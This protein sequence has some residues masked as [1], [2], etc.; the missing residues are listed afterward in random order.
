MFPLLVPASILFAD[1]VD[2]LRRRRVPLWHAGYLLTE[3]VVAFSVAYFVL[4]SRA[5]P[6]P[7]R[8]PFGQA[9]QIAAP[10]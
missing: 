3:L 7:V 6:T 8:T 2:A 4:S 1:R 5:E 9:R 10:Q